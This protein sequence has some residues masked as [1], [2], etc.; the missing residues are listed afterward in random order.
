MG[1]LIIEALSRSLRDTLWQIV[2]EA[3]N[4]DP[5]APVTVIGPSRY[6]NL[7]LRQELGRT[8]FINV[9][10]NVLP[11]LME[12]LG[13]ASLAGEGRNPLTSVIG[14]V[15]LRAVL[16]DSEGYLAPVRDHPSTLASIRSSFREFQRVDGS[17]IETLARQDSV[18]GEVARLYRKFRET[19]VPQWFEVDDLAAAATDAVRNHATSGLDDLGHLVFYL[20]PR[21]TPAETALFLELARQNRCS[22]LLG[23]TG[24]RDADRPGME[25]AE[26]LSPAFA[27]SVR[28][29]DDANGQPP[30]TE[31]ETSLHIAPNAH[32]ELRRVIRQIFQE[33]TERKTPFHRMAVLYRMDSP[34]ATLIPDE[35][36]LAGIPMA[37][38]GRD[39]LAESGVGR[40][41]LGMLRLAGGDYPR[42]EVMSWLTGCPVMPPYGRTPGF[43]PSRW[44]MLTRRA[45]VVSGVE[46]WTARLGQY[47]E[48]LEVDADEKERMG[49]IDDV[50]AA[51]MKNEAASARNA[52]AFVVQL[53][54]DLEPPQSRSTWDAWSEW[55]KRL[56][57]TYLS[58]QL[59]EG[60]MAADQERRARQDVEKM[61]KQL[62]SADVFSGPPD[63][64]GFRQAV[65]EELKVPR[66]ALGPTGGG[67]F[68]SSFSAAVGMA[69][70]AVWLVG[71]IEGGV[72]PSVRPDPL[73]PESGWLAAGGSSRTQEQTAAERFDY[74]LVLASSPRRNLS[75][76]VADGGSQRQAYPSRW[77]LEQASLLDGRRIYA[78]DL[79]SLE[80]RSWLTTDHSGQQAL[81]RTPDSSLADLHDYQLHRLVRW[82]E[83]RRRVWQHPLAAQ[84]SLA[85]S[86]QSGLSR[87][88]SRWTEFDGN[89]TS[90]AA[91]AG[92][93]T[94]LEQGAMS[95]TRLE[96]WAACP[97]RY[98]LGQV[99]RLSALETPEETV[100]IGAADR[101]ALVHDILERFVRE[102]V[103]SGTLPVPGAHWDAGSHRRLWEISEEAFRE[104]EDRGLTG[105]PLLW[106][107]ARQGIREDLESFLEEDAGLRALHGAGRISV[108]TRFGFES[109][110]LEVVDE[111]TQVKFRGFIDRLDV[112]PDG[113]RVSVIDYKTGSATPYASLKDDP[114]DRGKR[115]QLGVYSMAAQRLFPDADTVRAAYW[116]TT[117]SGGFAKAPP[118][119]F[120]I[121]DE[122]VLERFRRGISTIVSGIRQGVFPAN[123][124]PVTN[125]GETTDYQNCHFCD[126]QS[127]CPARRGEMWQ[128]KK[129][130]GHLAGYI[131]LAEGSVS[132]YSEEE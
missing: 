9:R 121:G 74:L 27:G 81:S 113:S 22:V 43:N 46:Q 94:N 24:D 109:D 131:S 71:M 73:L 114:I 57:D 35:L 117:N 80:D 111:E 105:K 79:P 108:E 45:G 100:A 115:L 119:Y 64:A 32:E 8:G 58:R 6:A 103:A 102:A 104:A 55:A 66:G 23:L 61:L 41:L 21:L 38:P 98:F 92:F 84:G 39:T 14:G 83:Q 87:N 88:Q 47:A 25:L 75:Y 48:G 20:P 3:K 95:P 89:L 72:P 59:P 110:A 78:D 116:F 5:L 126:F 127:L 91:E 96:S 36:D 53:S 28:R 99:L 101:G 82:R 17:V 40:T 56:L 112:S 77:F 123:P 10:F 132:E 51:A 85:R 67:L 49:D 128:R 69:F 11:A 120:D 44:D 93:G 124:G 31:R 130:D 1:Q 90:V 54:R 118:D 60:Q 125:F 50:R 76:P 106:Q 4:G 63:L 12:Q 107:L 16:A 86:I 19:I 29:K 122:E 68:V 42:R 30:Q 7:S 34:Y 26:A 37:G 70:D 65:E 18:S 52:A 13:S 33:A 129:A 2:R 97:F 15:A 62:P